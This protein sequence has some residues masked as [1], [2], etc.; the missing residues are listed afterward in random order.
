M[1]SDGL[2]LRLRFI[3]RNSDTPPNLYARKRDAIHFLVPLKNAARLRGS[4]I[5][6]D[7]MTESDWR[8][9]A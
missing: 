7:S 4:G 1:L 6:A 2:G 3:S 9:S 8:E 5:N